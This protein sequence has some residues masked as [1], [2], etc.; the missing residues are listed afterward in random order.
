M[1]CSYLDDIADAGYCG[2][3]CF[4]DVLYTCLLVLCMIHATTHVV[5]IRVHCLCVKPFLAL[6]FALFHVLAN[7]NVPIESED[8]IHSAG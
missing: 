2:A 4:V 8:E 1:R 3:R 5:S 7:P 6:L